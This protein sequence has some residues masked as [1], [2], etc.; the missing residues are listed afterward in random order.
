[1][2]L[3]NALSVP[4]RRVATWPNCNNNIQLCML[5]H[6]S[7]MQHQSAPIQRSLFAVE[8]TVCFAQDSRMYVLKRFNGLVAPTC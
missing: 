7:S 5:Q 4:Q 8:S 3:G 6:C 2:A 1:M